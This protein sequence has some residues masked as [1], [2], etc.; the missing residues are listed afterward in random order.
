MSNVVPLFPS[1]NIRLYTRPDCG[2]CDKAK[3]FL[4]SK[5]IDYEEV[6]IDDHK[7]ELLEKY[8]SLKLLPVV[9]VDGLV[10]GSLDELTELLDKERYEQ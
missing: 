6:L 10:I 5:N 1:K 7:T 4:L 9:E 2:R 3:L 8:P